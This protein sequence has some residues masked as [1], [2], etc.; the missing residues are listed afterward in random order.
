MTT[1]SSRPRWEPTSGS[2][3]GP[4]STASACRPPGT[5]SGLVIKRDGLRKRCSY[6]KRRSDQYAVYVVIQEPSVL[7][8]LHVL[9]DYGE[10][11][12]VVCAPNR[13]TSRPRFTFVAFGMPSFSLIEGNLHCLDSYLLVIIPL[14]RVL[15]STASEKFLNCIPCGRCPSCFI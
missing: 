13:K 9:I 6:P 15:C 2:P 8:Q 5:P 7:G 1:S 10:P 14:R 11:L 4:A 12:N 3:N